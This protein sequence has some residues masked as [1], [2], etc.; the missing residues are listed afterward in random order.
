MQLP[1]PLH[2]SSQSNAIVAKSNIINKNFDLQIIALH[3]SNS[4]SELHRFSFKKIFI[5]LKYCFIIIYKTRVFKPDLVYFTLSPEGYGFLRDSFYVFI[6]QLLQVK[7][8]FHLHG[9]GIKNSS[10]KNFFKRAL[11]KRVFKNS[12]TI[13]LANKLTNDIKSVSLS[14]P[15]IVPNG[16]PVQERF[17]KNDSKIDCNNIKILFLSNYKESKGVLILIDALIILKKE[18]YKFQARL[19]GGPSDLSIDFLKNYIKINEIENQIEIVGPKYNEGKY[20]EL[21]NADIFVLP[22]L[23][24]AFPLVNLEAMQFS[25]PIITT[26]EGGISEAVLDGITGFVIEPKNVMQLAEK[27]SILIN[28]KELREN[29]GMKGKEIFFKQF[30]VKHFEENLKAVFEKILNK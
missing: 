11:Y 24:E 6:L 1:P 19:V 20:L 5:T 3:F 26:D 29:M 27:L 4:L 9:K 8:V 7:I 13:C 17:L 28:N 15:F 2:G 18:G 23:N 16:I 21:Q 22:T 30:T 12:D 10:E 14:Q 25:L